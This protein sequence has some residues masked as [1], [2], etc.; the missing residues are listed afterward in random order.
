MSRG[1]LVTVDVDA[2]LRERLDRLVEVLSSDDRVQLLSAGYER[3]GAP[4]SVRL[5]CSAT[6]DAPARAQ[7][8][9]ADALR[10]L[11]VHATPTAVEVDAEPEREEGPPW[12]VLVEIEETHPAN[13]QHRLLEELLAGSASASVG[14]ASNGTTTAFLA[15]DSAREH[16]EV[17]A[18][19]VVSE[20]LRRARVEAGAVRV[21][22]ISHPDGGPA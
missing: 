5:L 19:S 11:G 17:T 10:A 9:V 4:L 8:A 13:A 12:L 7:S 18:V 6:E 14:R 1:C 3:S 20:A 16:A 21:A 15:V 2:Q 22:S